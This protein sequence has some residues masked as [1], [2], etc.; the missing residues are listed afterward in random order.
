MRKYEIASAN[1]WERPRNDGGR[2]GAP[3]DDR[4]LHVIAKQDPNVLKQSRDVKGR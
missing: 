2:A 1:A 4:A 3:R